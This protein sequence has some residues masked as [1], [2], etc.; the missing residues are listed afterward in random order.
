MMPEALVENWQSYNDPQAAIK[1]A[2]GKNTFNKKV[3]VAVCNLLKMNLIVSK[4]LFEGASKDIKLDTI[5]NIADPVAKHLQLVRSMPP[6][7]II[8]TMCGMKRTENLKKN[9]EVI[10]SEPL[11]RDEFAKAMNLK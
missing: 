11:T 1:N 8:S 2:D 5:K 3:L 7:C 4:P 10:K 6:R 9:F